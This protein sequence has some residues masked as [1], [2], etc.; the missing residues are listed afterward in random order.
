MKAVERVLKTI[1]LEEPDR[2]PTF[3]A[4]IDNYYLHKHVGLKP[5]LEGGVKLQK[6]LYNLFLGSKKL[7]NKVMTKL[8]SGNTYAK[9]FVTDVTRLYKRLG[10]DLCPIHA[11]LYPLY[12][13]KDGMIDEF[14]RHIKYQKIHNFTT[15]MYHGGYFKS[16]EDYEAFPK[17]DPD[18]PIREKMIRMAK[19]FDQES[20]GEVY[21]FSQVSGSMELAWEGFGIENFSRIL[22]NKK[23]A[24]QIFDDRGKFQVEMVKRII[25]WGEE[26]LIMTGD[27]YGYKKG[28]FM[29]PKNYREYVIPWLKRL[30]DTAHKGGLK[31]ALHSC[32]DISLLLDDI[33]NAGVDALHPIE[34][35]T[36]N[37]EYDIFKLKEKYGDKLCFMGNVSPQDL[38][39]KQPDDIRAY[40]K[41]LIKNIGVGGG[42][43][44]G[45][46]HSI[47]PAAKLENFLAMHDTVKKYGNYPLS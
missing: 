2:V 11:Q 32:G 24:K 6:N 23:Q 25:E 4:A 22:R 28:L 21:T 34:P 27:D 30:C 16:F 9:I 47:T 29:S 17:P 12:Y 38:A 43:I 41:K 45:S 37:P 5:S 1:N 35:T 10:I 18:L 13:E 33:I 3:E 46:A 14:G 19:K 40:T 36:A 31:V 42:L 44:V 26:N 15:W 39:D 20:N 7:L 8:V